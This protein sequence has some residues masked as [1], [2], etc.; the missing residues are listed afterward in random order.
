METLL[1]CLLISCLAY[2]MIWTL[3]QKKKKKKFCSEIPSGKAT[4]GRLSLLWKAKICLYVWGGVPLK[5]AQRDLYLVTRRSLNL[6]FPKRQN[7]DTLRNC[8]CNV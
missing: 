8:G 5:L 2:E 3:F 7:E 6:L 1:F 4:F